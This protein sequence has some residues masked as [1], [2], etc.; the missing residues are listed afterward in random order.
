MSAFWKIRE[1]PLLADYSLTAIELT[2][3]FAFLSWRTNV[4]DSVRWERKFTNC[5]GLQKRLV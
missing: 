3:S 4:H 1:S 2:G 5:R